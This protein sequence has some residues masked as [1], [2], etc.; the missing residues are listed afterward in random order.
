MCSA[1]IS[2][3]LLPAF[4]INMC[5]VRP[6]SRSALVSSSRISAT[7]TICIDVLLVF[8]E[9]NGFLCVLSSLIVIFRGKR[10]KSLCYTTIY[11]KN[12]AQNN[13]TTQCPIRQH[14]QE[15]GGARTTRQPSGFGYQTDR[16]CDICS[17]E[18]SVSDPRL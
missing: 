10:R 3:A 4:S 6:Y 1:R 5:E 8:M 15:T 12:R 14:D 7:V 16:A 17:S 18:L 13:T 2:A 9:V 11:E